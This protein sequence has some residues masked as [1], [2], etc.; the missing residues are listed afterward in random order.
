MIKWVS[1]I[2]S[3]QSEMM[4]TRT[5]GIVDELRIFSDTIE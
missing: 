5:V 1:I 2:A 3:L 4:R